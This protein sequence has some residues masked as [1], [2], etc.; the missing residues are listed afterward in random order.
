M[1]ASP[2]GR[3]KWI[4]E[5]LSISFTRSHDLRRARTSS[6]MVIRLSQ[7]PACRASA[8][9]RRRWLNSRMAITMASRLVDALEKRMASVSSASGISTVVFMIPVCTDSDSNSSLW[10]IQCA[11]IV[12]L[13]QWSDSVAGIFVGTEIRGKPK[14]LYKSARCVRDIDS[15]LSTNL[16][17]ANLPSTRQLTG[18]C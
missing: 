3:R 4:H 18:K 14:N 8:A 17:W 12:P 13:W 15:F 5:E 16:R 2:L 10:L 1:L 9:I 7:L 11:S 6:E